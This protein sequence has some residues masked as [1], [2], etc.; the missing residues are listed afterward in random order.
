MVAVRIPV[1]VKKLYYSLIWDIRDGSRTVYLTF[2]DGPTPDIT[3]RVLGLLKE[4]DA[5]ATFF[6]IGRNVEHYPGLYRMILDN[7]HTVG[8]HTYSHL[9]GWKTRNTEYYQDIELAGCMVNSTLFRPPYGRIKRSQLKHLVNK[10][11]IIM[12]DVM[13]YDFDRNITKQQCLQNV[14]N[15]TRPGSIVVFH[16]SVKA[17]ERMLFA[18]EGLLKTLAGKNY[19]FKSITSEG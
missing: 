2:D 18:A 13:S 11:K 9:A 8:N 4:Y 5:K 7:G 16:D 6:C 17:G 19:K 10:Y 12:W 15:H 3:P 14:V 1:I